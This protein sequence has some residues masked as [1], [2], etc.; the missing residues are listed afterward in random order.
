MTDLFQTK[1]FPYQLFKN[2]IFKMIHDI[3]S[4]Y[5]QHFVRVYSSLAFA[6]VWMNQV[7]ISIHAHMY[8]AVFCTRVG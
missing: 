5:H 1:D 8:I 4:R 3:L 7:L 6:F 2:T